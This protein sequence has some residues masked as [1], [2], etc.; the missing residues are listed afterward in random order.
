MDELK[1]IATRYLLGELS[2]PEQAALE[3]RYFRDPVVFNKVLQVESE[4]V[5]AYAR[6]Q[7]STEM[8][9]RFE[10][11]YLKH[12]ARRNRVEFARAL[13]S[14]IDEREGSVTH[15]ERSALHISWHQRL[16]AIVGG[17][18][19]ALRFATALIV[20]AIAL[21][22]IWILIKSRGRQQQGEVAQSQAPQQPRETPQQTDKPP[23]QE[24]QIP[25]ENSQ[26]SL[27]S[28]PQIVS[29]ALTVGGV[30][31]ADGGATPTLS[32][33]HDTTQAQIVLEL[34]DDSY[35]RY[36][37]SLRKIEGSEIFTQTNLKP[38]R[39]KTGARFVF[40][41]PAKQLT[42]GDYALTLGGITPEGEVDELNKSLFRV[43]KP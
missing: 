11:S 31:S 24:A 23:P 2:E 13:T 36:R 41:I 17:Q 35:S 40:T 30:R 8:R 38:R 43:K 3:E 15:A 42:S 32:I 18:R 10:D 33:P 29:L 12:P 7:L 27:S 37:A 9:K 14:R 21:A 19:P 39:T 34:K 28:A 25:S 26:P 20:I 4:L 6:G 22:G 5:D 1:Q 16:L